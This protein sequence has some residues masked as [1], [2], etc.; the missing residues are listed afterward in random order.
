MSD[1]GIKKWAPYKSLVKQQGT[2]ERV[3]QKKQVQEKPLISNEEAEEINNILTNYH[4]ETLIVKYYRNQRLYEEE[5]IIK[6]IDVYEK[7]L[8]LQDR[9]RIK[10]NEIVDLKIK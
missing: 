10:L 8:V 1:R 3:S 9:R 5:I 6:T 4:G 2:L 7:K